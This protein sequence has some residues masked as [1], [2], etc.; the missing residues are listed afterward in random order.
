MKQSMLS[1]LRCFDAVCEHLPAFGPFQPSRGW[2]SA[3]EELC[4]GKLEG[5]VL[6]HS[7]VP[8]PEPENSITVRSALNQARFQPWPAFWTK[9]DNALLLGRNALWRNDKNKFCLEAAYHTRER[10]R[11]REDSL[12][13]RSWVGDAEALPGAWTSVVSNWGDGRN[14]FH[15]LLDNLTR[16]MA[17]NQLPEG[18]RILIP[19]GLPSF[20]RETLELLGLVESCTPVSGRPLR[21]ER[22][23]FCSPVAM[24]GVWNP[25]GFNW[26]RN[27][28]SPYFS[29]PMSQGRIFLTRRG[30][31]RIPA[32]LAEIEEL[33]QQSGFRIIDP[34]SLTV[35]EQIQLASGATAIAGIH[36]A[37]MA[38]LLWC[39]PATPVLE[40]FGSSYLNGC[41]EQISLQGNLD[42]SSS[43]LGENHA[44]DD[45]RNWIKKASAPN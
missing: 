17:R 37:A 36:G 43:I 29:Q 23:Y 20:A 11:I 1:I 41:Y 42:Y 45:M 8:G 15:W 25:A 21:P 27:Q 30:T 12:F 2:F 26:L 18:T 7:Q 4:N 14:Y 16:L 24:T 6:F 39:R 31:N 10:R 33:F 19:S 34:G 9:S 40:I 22:F 5:E 28:F 3:Y 35:R 38:N 13:A 44:Y 32:D